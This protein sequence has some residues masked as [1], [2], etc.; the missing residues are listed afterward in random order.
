MRSA[1]R[2]TLAL[3]L[4]AALLAAEVGSDASAASEPILRTVTHDVGTG[5]TRRD[6]F[7]RRAS[8]LE[9]RAARPGYLPDSA[10]EADEIP[11][12]RKV[13]GADDREPV[14]DT[15]LYPWS[16]VA[17]VI[18]T[19]PDGLV[20]EGSAVMV[21]PY[22]ALTAGHVV[23]DEGHGGWARDVEVL[24]GYDLGFAPFGSHTADEI[25]SFA[26]FIDD[27]DYAYD[28]ALLELDA[29]AGESTGWLGISA[30][31]D[32][33]LL[34]NL[35]N[36]AGYPGD[37]E[38]GEGMWYAA[39]FADDV[40][41][42]SIYLNGTLDAAQ[43]QS[44]SGVWLRDGGERYVVGVV[45]T[46]TRNFNVAARITDEV[47]DTLDGWLGGTPTSGGPSDGGGLPDGTDYYAPIA[48]PAKLS[49]RLVPDE[50]VQYQF[51]I[52]Q[53]MQALKFRLRG[54]RFRGF[55]LV[56]R[57]DGSTFQLL[58]RLW[59]KTIENQP[60]LGQWRIIVKNRPD[61]GRSRRF[62]LNIKV[63]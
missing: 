22:Q 31:G 33:D 60:Q 44:G 57:P 34:D 12:P 13:F 16:T 21:G 11:T 18:S 45:S 20:A 61:A 55:A 63:K 39:D 24:P 14:Y 54:Q 42:G 50:Q 6:T 47:F 49:G 35:M 3:G 27:G 25:L 28:F 59:Y 32:A 26:G 52:D 38:D 43:G 46:E 30:R 62:K 10:F 53:P 29:D 41:A 40:D 8:L 23:Y 56:V 37:L 7:H 2:L 51:R 58:P 1:A 17:K 48:I 15:D 9:A 36:T 5:V 19:F 4:G